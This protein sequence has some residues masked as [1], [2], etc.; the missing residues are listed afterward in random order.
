MKK[1]IKNLAVYTAAT[2]A[3]VASVVAIA[4]LAGVSVPTIVGVLVV[5]A[6]VNST[7]G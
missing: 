1:F 2:V 5:G 3:L 4:S 6:I 7:I